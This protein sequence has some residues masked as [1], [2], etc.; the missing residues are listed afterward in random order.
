MAVDVPFCSPFPIY[1]P[2]SLFSPHHR[3]SNFI[4]PIDEIET[5]EFMWW[6]V[7]ER[8]SGQEK[9]LG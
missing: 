2:F 7:P 3:Q 1:T 5:H 6:N 8:V 4:S 9:L